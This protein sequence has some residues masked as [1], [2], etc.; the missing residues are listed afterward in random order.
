[1]I[2]VFE[3]NNSLEANIIKSRLENEGINVFIAGEYLQGGIGELP[4]MGLMRIMVDEIYEP[5]ARS[6]I[7]QWQNMKED[8]WH[9]FA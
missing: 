4:A 6:L 1:M 2:C 3:A 9:P 8:D 5:R 7:E